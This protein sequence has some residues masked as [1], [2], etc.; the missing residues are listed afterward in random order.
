MSHQVI[1]SPNIHLFAYH[2]QN[3]KNPKQLYEKCDELLDK[4]KISDFNLKQ[5]INLDKELDRFRVDLIKE[6]E[7]KNDNVSPPFEGKLLLDEQQIKIEGFAYPLR[8]DDSYALALNL[9]CPEE[10]QNCQKNVS[11]LK[12]F[13]PDNCL[14]P[15]FIAGSLGQTLL[16]TA[17]LPEKQRELYSEPWQLPDDQ[18]K[19]SEIALIELANECLNALI[20]DCQKQPKL[21]RQGQLFGSP[22]FEYGILSKNTVYQHILLWLFCTHEADKKFANCYQ[23]FIDL[24]CYRN[25]II[26]SYTHSREIFP[27]LEA[28]YK[29]IEQEIDKLENL[30]KRYNLTE[31]DLNQLEV[32]IKNLVQTASKY[33]RY[34][35]QLEQKRHIIAVHTR[36]YVEKLRVIKS[37]IEHEYSSW[38][39]N[40]ISFLEEFSRK[41]CRRFQE[42]IQADL[43]YFAPGSGLIDQ[44]IASIRVLVEI[45]QLRINRQR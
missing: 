29:N 30:T 19:L 3:S 14:L 26:Q 22:I 15:E 34:L 5:R 4:L 40:D 9:R 33:A 8:I 28:N 2:F 21:H 32:Q 24:F 13:N 17:W 45:E 10:G 31:E 20:P 35:Q 38:L 39:G 16:I 44:A 36:N 41:K 43:A 25:Q 7:I 42:Q 1:Y 23:D 18:Q 6:E 37:I 11:F 27:I 12:Q